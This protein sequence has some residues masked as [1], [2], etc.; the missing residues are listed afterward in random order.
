MRG[1]Q[2]DTDILV[3]QV[4]SHLAVLRMSGRTAPD[5]T[6]A[7]R[8]AS[9]LREMIVSTT[10]ASAADRARVRAAVH[11]FVLRREGRDGRFPARSL[12]A[13]QRVVNEI[14]DALGRHDLIV[15]TAAT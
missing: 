2:H 7:E 4:D 9:S 6:L 14:A 11:Y 1:F 13:D 15:Q 12:A 10:R 8:L 5:L 3:R